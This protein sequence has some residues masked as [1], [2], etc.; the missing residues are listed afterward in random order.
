MKKRM[1]DVAARIKKTDFFS[2]KVF[3][4]L[5]SAALVCIAVIC[6]SQVGLKNTATRRFFTKID[7][8]EGGYFEAA[9]TV[10]EKQETRLTLHT[11]STDTKN[12]KIYV[13]GNEYAN[14]AEGDNY[15][16]ISSMSVIEIYSP[17]KSVTVEITEVSDGLVVYTNP[18]R[19]TAD[20]EIKLLG[21]VGIR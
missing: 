11:D 14:L 15:V 6:V 18:R 12:A 10:S 3:T 21:R 5:Y 16:D 9:V 2:S 4:A 19:V 20:K 8:Y 17:D 7:E 13:N 1:A